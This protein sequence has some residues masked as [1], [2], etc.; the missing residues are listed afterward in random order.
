ML[1][2]AENRGPLRVFQLKQNNNCVAV[3]P[4]E[5]YAVIQFKNGKKR[6]EEFYY[7][8]SYLSQSSR[9]IL[10]NSNIKSIRFYNTKGLSRIINY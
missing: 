9:F 1:A 6:K 5:N 10:I 8:S 4:Y 2:A 3:L 7:G